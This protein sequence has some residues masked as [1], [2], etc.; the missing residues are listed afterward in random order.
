VSLN[1]VFRFAFGLALIF[2]VPALAAT[3]DL[4]G[5]YGNATGCRVLAGG[6]YTSDDKLILR[7]DSVEA[8]ESVCEFVEV[9]PAKRGASVVKS[10]C[11]GEGSMWTR[12]LIISG[13]DEENNTR[14]IFNDDGSLWA[15]VAPCG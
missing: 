5:V 1:R 4:P 10:L 3:L 2:P 12:D 6:A 8:H 13:P 15:E 9:L 14:L 11:E 7:P